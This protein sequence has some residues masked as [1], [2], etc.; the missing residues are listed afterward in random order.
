M[1]KRHECQ[2][3]AVTCRGNLCIRG[4][5][6][7]HVSYFERTN[8]ISTVSITR[9]NGP[10]IPRGCEQKVQPLFSKEMPRKLGPERAHFEGPIQET[11]A[12]GTSKYYWRCNYCTYQLGGQVF[13]NRKA[14]I[15][16]SGDLKLR[17]GIVAKVCDKAPEE[18]KQKFAELVTAKRYY[19]MY[20]PTVRVDIYSMH[21]FIFM[22]FQ[23]F[24][25]RT[26]AKTQ[27]KTTVIISYT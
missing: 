15:H 12:S 13:Q 16:L 10:I 24:Y 4:T 21:L 27:A 11:N 6:Q 23:N 25:G 26:T 20:E 18:I 8:Y 14:R 22:F 17:N 1:T 9:D 2:E 3:L 5:N 7:S 19:A